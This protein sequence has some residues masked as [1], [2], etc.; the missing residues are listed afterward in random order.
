MVSTKSRSLFWLQLA[1]LQEEAT[2]LQL[3]QLSKSPYP[4]SQRRTLG[5]AQRLQRPR[6]MVINST[7]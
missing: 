6:R 1:F 3:E 5:S 4:Y 2:N 7:P